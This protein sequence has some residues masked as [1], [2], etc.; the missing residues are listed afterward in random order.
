MIKLLPPGLHI[1]LGDVAGG[2]FTRVF[3][4]RDRLL[5]D[6]DVLSVGPTPRCTDL[7]AWN[8]LRHDFWT[9]F[10]PGAASEHVHSR[11]NLL[12]NAARLSDAG[13]VNVWAATGVSEQ[14]FIASVVHLVKL[15]GGETENISLVLFEQMNG[16]R[17]NALGELD[18]AQL[19]AAPEP[20]P[21]SIDDLQHYLNAWVA[22]TSP[23]PTEISNY[24]RVHADA[25]RWLKLAM[26]LMTRRFP[27]KRTGLT[28]WDHAL[29]SRVE[30]RGPGASHIIGFT[31]AET[32]AQ[33][34][35]VGDW[36]LFGR[37]LRLGRGPRPLI[38]L[39]GDQLAIHSTE[40]VITEFGKEV[41]RGAA[42]NYPANPID[43]WAAGVKLSSA[44]RTLWFNDGGKLIPG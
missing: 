43:D 13:R 34:D 44:D 42:S 21:M 1:L 8:K 26:Q 24:A 29:L 38:T 6:Q 18:E 36:Y 7:A 35:S 27:D 11:F 20:K 25:N 32:Y 30:Q 19:R 39:S 10:V 15:V 3:F 41:L 16:M 31:M 40:A 37:L 22:L 33:G 5:I 4:A 28:Y 9:G 14:L 17:V 23:D 12:D 2:I